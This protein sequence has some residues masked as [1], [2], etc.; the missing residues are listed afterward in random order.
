MVWARYF[1]VARLEGEEGRM[2]VE[3]PTNVKA[4]E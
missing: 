4:V 2:M 3:A 1:R